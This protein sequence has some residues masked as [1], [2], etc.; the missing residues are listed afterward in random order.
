MSCRYGHILTTLNEVMKRKNLPFEKDYG[1][2]TAVKKECKESNDNGLMVLKGFGLTGCSKY[3]VYFDIPT[4][5]KKETFYNVMQQGPC[6]VSLDTRSD[7]L[8]F[9]QSGIIDL[10]KIETLSC[11]FGRLNMVAYAWKHQTVAQFVLSRKTTRY[12]HDSCLWKK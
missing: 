2:Y 11:K 1:E 8:K 6:G 12:V 7:E 4:C 5:E 3:G 10:T 9:Y